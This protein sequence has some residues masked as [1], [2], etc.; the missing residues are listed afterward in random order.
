[1]ALLHA[2]TNTASFLSHCTAIIRPT[3]FS[4][5]KGVCLGLG[6]VWTLIKHLI[7]RK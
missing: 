3:I 4:L 1:M 7:G 5:M 6:W 2:H